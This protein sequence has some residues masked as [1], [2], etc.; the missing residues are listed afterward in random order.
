MFLQAKQIAK[1]LCPPS[2]WSLLHWSKRLATAKQRKAAAKAANPLTIVSTL[3]ELDVLLAEAKRRIA[4][5]F[6]EC[7]NYLD[8]I[9]FATP[10]DLPEDPTSPEYRER[11]MAFYRLLS[12]LESY[13][14]ME[15]EQIAVDEDKQ[16]LPFPYYTRSATVVGE[17]LMA[18]GCMIRASEVAPRSRVLEFGPGFGR[19]TLEFARMDLDVTAVE[20][21]PLYVDLIRKHA[22]REN[23]S[24]NVVQSSMLDFHSDK[25]FDRVFFYESFHHCEDHIAMI[26]KFDELV[27]PN[28]AVVFG[29][30]PIED[31]F[32]MP[33]GVRCD[34]RAV[35][36]I[37]VY[38]WL[39]LGFRTDYFISLLARHGWTTKI[40]P[41]QDVPWQRVFVAK[42]SRELNQ[43]LSSSVAGNGG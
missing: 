8:T 25:Q 31:N 29:G 38:R 24:V 7:F 32:P 39:E 11:Q 36:A 23:L 34:G 35:W 30:E 3:R 17:Q 43:S 40:V 14:A 12:G 26:R 28:G 1:G 5:S 6:D 18:I 13:T 37:R 9:R 2:L 21:N 16:R 41:S 19:L 4:I 15:C 20:I 27:A 10:T 42:R 22:V 33:W